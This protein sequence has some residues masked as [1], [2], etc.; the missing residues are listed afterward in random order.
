MFNNN[1]NVGIGVGSINNWIGIFKYL[2]KTL[3]TGV[4]EYGEILN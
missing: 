3:K 4:V 1:L 2:K